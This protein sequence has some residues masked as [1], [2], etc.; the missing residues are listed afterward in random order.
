MGSYLDIANSLGMWLA[1]S[2][3][4]VVVVFQAIRL[5][6]ISFKAGLEI[7]LTKKQMFLAFRTGFTTTLVPSIPILL[8]LVLLMPRLGLAF[9]WMRLSVIGSVSYELIAAGMAASE[10]GLEGLSADM[11]ATAFTTMVWTMSLG[12]VLGLFVVAFFTPKISKLKDK[13]AGGDEGWM[14]AMTAAAFF[15][16]VSYM[17]TQ[18]VI[19]GGAPL[20]ALIGGFVAMALLGIIVTVLKLNWLKEWALS[21]SIILGMVATGFG[22]H[23]FGIGG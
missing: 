12:A 4:I 13:I 9:P 2:A 11:D 19:K 18:P 14:K 10:L 8:G 1:C 5:S 20:V 6:M 21:L 15:G 7:G 3:I 22:F 16:A 17:V 23:F